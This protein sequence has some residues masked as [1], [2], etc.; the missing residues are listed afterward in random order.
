MKTIARIRKVGGEVEDRDKLIRWINMLLDK[1]TD[2]EHLIEISPTDRT[3]AQNKFY[4]VCVRIIANTFG[5]S[6]NDL[7]E[8]FK[9]EWLPSQ[10]YFVLTKRKQ[11]RSTS[12]MTKDEMSEYLEKVIRLAAEQGIVIPDPEEYKH[13]INN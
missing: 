6:P 3:D 13:T 5:V 7:H 12:E 1:M 11:V 2:G 9:S 4:W 10:E 8:H